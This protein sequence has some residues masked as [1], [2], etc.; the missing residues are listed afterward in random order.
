MDVRITSRILLGTVSLGRIDSLGRTRRLGGDD[1]Q[2]EYHRVMHSIKSKR[3]RD[4]GL[5]RMIVTLANPNT[6]PGEGRQW[7]NDVL[8]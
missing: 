6:M 1:E 5:S 3:R 2:R 4:W 7:A 8:S